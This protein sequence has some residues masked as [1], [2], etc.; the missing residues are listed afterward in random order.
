MGKFLQDLRFGARTLFRSPGFTAVAVISLALGIG[1]VTTVYSMVAAVVLNP[2]P[3]DEA[4]RLLSFKTTRPSRG[5]SHFSVSYGDFRDWQEQNRSFEQ[6]AVFTG[7]GLN[8][9][10][11]EGPE[12]V[13]CAAAPV[14]IC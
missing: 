6:I 8:L 10:G 4:N 13:S 12:P 7:G 5:D 2:L 3:F 11:P 9:S 14:G 1:A